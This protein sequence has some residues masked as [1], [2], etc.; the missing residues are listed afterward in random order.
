MWIRLCAGKNRERGEKEEGAGAEREPLTSK[1]AGGD[2]FEAIFSPCLGQLDANA[3]N[4]HG[5]VLNYR[6]QAVGARS[7]DMYLVHEGHLLLGLLRA[8]RLIILGKHQQKLELG[9]GS[10]QS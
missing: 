2:I 5:H 1:R 6:L 7:V 4:I 8:V 10:G 9:I 3:V